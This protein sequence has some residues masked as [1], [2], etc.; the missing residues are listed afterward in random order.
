MCTREFLY[1][2]SNFKVT[3]N[4]IH[5]KTNQ[6]T[7]KNW[8]NSKSDSHLVP[9]TLLICWTYI[10]PESS[11]VHHIVRFMQNWTHWNWST[12]NTLQTVCLHFRL[13]R[14]VYKIW[15]LTY[16]EMH[17]VDMLWVRSSSS[18]LH[19][20]QRLS[21]CYSLSNTVGWEKSIQFKKQIEV[22]LH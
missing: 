17:G 2:L 21:L 11:E 18:Y 3:F 1:D 15:H 20:T 14:E 19:S 12:G 9:S 7:C 6:L 10:I 13:R 5:Q 8:F 16:N 4:R 22:H